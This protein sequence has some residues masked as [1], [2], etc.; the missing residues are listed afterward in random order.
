M[1][2][3][4]APQHLKRS[5]SHVIKHTKYL[6]VTHIKLDE[7]S[8][9]LGTFVLLSSYGCRSKTNNNNTHTHRSLCLYTGWF[10]VLFYGSNQINYHTQM[11]FLNDFYKLYKYQG[12][13][14]HI[15]SYA[16]PRHI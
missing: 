15:C 4:R 13:S 1:E 3:V 10:C 5:H 9:F 14:L 8:M 6:E 2:T 12:A 11:I 7:G 16:V